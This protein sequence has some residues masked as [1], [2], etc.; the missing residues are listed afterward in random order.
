[1]KEKLTS[2]QQ[3]L[4]CTCGIHLSCIP[5][6]RQK[7]IELIKQR[8]NHAFDEFLSRNDARLQHILDFPLRQDAIYEILSPGG[9]IFFTYLDKPS[10]LLFLFGPIMTRPFSREDVLGQM[11]N[12]AI[13]S[14][15][16]NEIM[17]F[18]APIPVISADRVYRIVETCLRQLLGLTYPLKILQA[19][20]VHSVESLLR[21]SLSDITPEIVQMRQIEIRY[22]YSAALVEA[23]KQGNVSLA[24]HI[25]GQY[26]PD[27]DYP[28]RN[29]NPLRNSQNY[30]IILNTQ[31]R[32]A[33]EECGVHPYA[34]D[35]LSSEIGLQIE[36]L[37]EVSKF[38][39]FFVYVIQQY[40]RLVQ[41]HAFP[42]LNPL[43]SLTVEYIKAHL[44]ENLTVKDTAK[45]L[46][47][48]ANYLSTQFH[49]NMGMTFIDFVNTE[50]IRQAASL[51]QNTNLQIQQ[52]SQMIGYNNTSYFSKQ[53]ARHMNCS[54]R[55]YR[56]HYMNS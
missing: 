13:P 35:K 11:R 54:P 55:Q 1:M 39:D 37:T 30:C 50:R 2:I 9:I 20:T 12:L 27:S 3:L 10:N 43:T 24:L 18:W 53:F 56:K 47:V 29:H 17:Q 52:I 8:T 23:I 26:V 51:L 33:M 34:V 25:A 14:H 31:L 16:E 7:L 21:S 22:E 4:E 40:C 49:Q 36:Q 32:H 46:T 45:A 44:S 48:N 6:S 19:N 5:Y 42:Q 15:M 28:V 38:K 41:Q